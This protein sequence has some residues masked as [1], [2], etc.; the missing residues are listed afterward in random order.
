MDYREY[1]VNPR[2]KGELL[3]FIL[4]ALKQCGCT[5]LCHSEPSLAPLR[6]TFE[7]PNGERMGIIVYAFF[8]NQRLTKNRPADEHRF[9]IK[10]GSKDGQLHELWQD[11]YEL[12]TTLFVGINPRLAACRT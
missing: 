12:Y 7:A 6:L 10:Y 4:Q 5:V 9:Q 3:Q 8:A 1:G 2:A 11:P